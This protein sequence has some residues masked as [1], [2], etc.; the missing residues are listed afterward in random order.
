MAY[1][2]VAL[3]INHLEFAVFNG[4]RDLNSFSSRVDHGRGP[5]TLTVLRNV[6]KFVAA[7]YFRKGTA[8]Q[9]IKKSMARR[10]RKF[11]LPNRDNI[12]CMEKVETLETTGSSVARTTLTKGTSLFFRQIHN[13]LYYGS[14]K[15]MDR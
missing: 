1:L 12:S 5:L 9:K 8:I 10:R 11:A 2:Q 6:Y 14:I 13:V 3:S 4:E 15:R 7:D